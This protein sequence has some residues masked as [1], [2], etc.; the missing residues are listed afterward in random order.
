MGSYCCGSETERNFRT[1]NSK[2]L[3][4]WLTLKYLSL[5][6]QI[7]LMYKYISILNVLCDF[8][9]LA[10]SSIALQPPSSMG[11][12]P[13]L[14]TSLVQH[15]VTLPPPGLTA[16]QLS[17]PPPPHSQPL[18]TSQPIMTVTQIPASQAGVVHLP[19][20]DQPQPPQAIPQAILTQPPPAGLQLQPVAMTGPPQPGQVIQTAPA[21]QVILLKQPDGS[22][23][24]AEAAPP[25]LSQGMPLPGQGLHLPVPA[26]QSLQVPGQPGQILQQ[27]PPQ[28]QLE[29]IPPGQPPPGQIPVGQIPLNQPPPS[30]PILTQPPPGQPPPQLEQP[31]PF[32]QPPPGVPPLS[33]PPPGQLLPP[34]QQP[35]PVPLVQQPP[36]HF[37]SSQAGIASSQGPPPPHTS[38]YYNQ[39]VVSSTTGA[40]PTSSSGPWRAE[41]REERKRRFT[42]EKQEDKLP[43]N[44]L[45]YKVLYCTYRGIETLKLS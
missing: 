37:G 21:Q 1:V 7:L 11:N 31:P 35:Q 14:S 29:Q 5:L 27:P 6:P 18:V 17:M 26:G 36:N 3:C 38:N 39:Y 30:Q 45:G 10:A 22:Q 32:S 25:P 4:N 33:Q 42:E 2:P 24:T 23:M 28:I 15:P 9:L 20:P 12:L 44:L 16:A 41:T 43:D 40:T 19:P 13:Q 8:H 34:V